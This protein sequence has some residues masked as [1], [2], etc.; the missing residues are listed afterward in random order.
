MDALGLAC[1][2][3][4]TNR[5]NL[6]PDA[7]PAT[8]DY[9]LALGSPFIVLGGISSKSVESLSQLKEI[10]AFLK[11]VQSELEKHGIEFGYHNHAKDFTY[12]LEGKSLFEHIFD[13]MP[14]NFLMELDTGNAMDSGMDCIALLKKYPN[15]AKYLHAKGFSQAKGYLA[16]IG[17]DDFNWEALLSC[18][19]HTGGTQFIDVEFGLRGD[20]DPLERAKTSFDNLDRIL[21]FRR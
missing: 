5:K 4:Y 10:I 12:F 20:Y 6:K 13:N 14:Q 8:I 15:R 17:Q 16:Y 11:D 3:L 2:G 7:L 1:Y 9:C 19:I 21:H 18:A